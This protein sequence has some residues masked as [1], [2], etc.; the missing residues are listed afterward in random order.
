MF[1]IGFT[2]MMLIG[3]VALVVIGP[4]RLPKVAREAGVYVARIRRFV[5][6]AKRDIESEL[7]NEDL[8]KILQQQQD[9]IQNLKEMVGDSKRDLGIDELEDAIRDIEH[10]ET[11]EPVAAKRET[12]EANKVESK[13]DSKT[14]THAANPASAAAQAANTTA[15]PSTT[16][17]EAPAQSA[18]K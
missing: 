2:E 6:N 17:P 15:A 5:Q 1:D 8:K 7:H 18:A 3:V 12:A 14:Q 9:E 13:P 10:N 16:P 4:E 11:P